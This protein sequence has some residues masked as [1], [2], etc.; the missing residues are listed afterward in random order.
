MVSLNQKKKKTLNS[1]FHLD[2]NECMKDNGGCE[3]NCTNEV[4]S[5]VC[6]CDTGYSIDDNGFNCTSE[7]SFMG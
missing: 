5:F 2:T 3:H 7:Y 6:G 4:G 1:K